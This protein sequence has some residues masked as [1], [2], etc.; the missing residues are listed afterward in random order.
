[1]M[2][3]ACAMID[4]T[5]PQTLLEIKGLVAEFRTE[6]GTVRA[7]KGVDLSVGAGET[8][9]LVGESGSGKSVTGLSIMRLIGRTRG[10]IANGQIL[11]S[12]RDGVRRDLVQEP[13][14]V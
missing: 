2:G 11:F 1:M 5:P 9:A 13:E 12:D 6:G 10:E 7:V 14:T 4:K 3:S 8:V